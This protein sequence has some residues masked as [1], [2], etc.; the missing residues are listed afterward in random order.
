MLCRKQNLYEQFFLPFGIVVSLILLAACSPASTPV[1]PEPDTPLPTA[2]DLVLEDAYPAPEQQG[3]VPEEPVSP[4]YPGPQDEGVTPTEPVSPAYP[5]P[6]MADPSPV[7]AVRLE[8]EATDPETVNLVAGQVQLV[9]F[10]A[11]W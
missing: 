8:L 9:E 1:P 11:F 2:G 5:A 6:D 3:D 4:A 7:P 10:F